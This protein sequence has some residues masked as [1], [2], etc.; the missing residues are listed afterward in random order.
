M[1]ENVSNPNA[2][3]PKLSF[4][5]KLMEML[6]K[7]LNERIDMAR[8]WFEKTYEAAEQAVYDYAKSLDDRFFSTCGNQFYFN[9]WLTVERCEDGRFLFELMVIGPCGEKIYSWTSGDCDFSL[10]FNC[11]AK[12]GDNV[13]E[14]LFQ[15]M[16]EILSEKLEVP[17]GAVYK[18]SLP[19]ES[20]YVGTVA[21]K[22]VQVPY[23][24]S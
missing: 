8:S 3:S 5:E 20:G 24:I 12:E 7:K 4:R 18:K 17:T 11:S 23:Y 19:L 22:Y 14:M 15:A 9:F 1:N 10:N 13:E 6:D 21:L 16:D 2:D